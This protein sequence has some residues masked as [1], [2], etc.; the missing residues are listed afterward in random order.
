MLQNNEETELNRWERYWT[1][2][3][4]VEIFIPSLTDLLLVQ[5]VKLMKEFL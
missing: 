3:I 2:L 4:S 5:C 1:A